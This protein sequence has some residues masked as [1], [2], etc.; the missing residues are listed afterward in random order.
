M[1]FD[2]SSFLAGF[3]VMSLVL[4]VGVSLAEWIR[5]RRDR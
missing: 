4:M 5:R 2:L 1:T 3:I